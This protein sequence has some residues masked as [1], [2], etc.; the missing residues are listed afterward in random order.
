MPEMKPIPGSPPEKPA[1]N[2]FFAILALLAAGVAGLAAF[3]D[4]LG[5]LG[6][7]AHDLCQFAK[8]CAGDPLPTPILA[9]HDSPK[10]GGGHNQNEQCE[11]LR[12][13][14]ASEN[15]GFN[16]AVQSWEDNDKDS[17]GHV[18]YHYHCRYVATPK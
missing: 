18:T 5:K 1:K 15:P 16:I 9:R 6:K 2:R 4:D 7:G 14:Y 12:A 13:K 10:M 11:P 3:T 17:F 8:V